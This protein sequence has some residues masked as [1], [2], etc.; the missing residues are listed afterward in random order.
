MKSRIAF[1]FVIALV[2]GMSACHYGS[3][4]VKKD[5][6]RNEEYKSK[7]A[8]KEAATALPAEAAVETGT[9][10]TEGGEGEDAPAA[11]TT[12]AE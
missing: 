9:Q 8:E 2:L 5:L 10:T 1:A 6:E 11:D 3:E 4:A 12:T 7:S